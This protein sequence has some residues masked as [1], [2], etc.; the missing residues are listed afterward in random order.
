MWKK[1]IPMS[2]IVYIA[3]RVPI[4]KFKHIIPSKDCKT[5]LDCNK[6]SLHIMQGDTQV[7]NSYQV[8]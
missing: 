2:R 1:G 8:T 3:F 5:R 6:R 7:Q 4:V